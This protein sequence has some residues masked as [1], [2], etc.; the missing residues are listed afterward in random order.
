MTTQ[1]SDDFVRRLEK[2]LESAASALKRAGSVTVVSHI[3][4]DGITS[5]AIATM[6]CERLSIPCKT[7]FAP[8]LNEEYIG[9][10]NAADSDLVWVTDLGSG[11]LSEFTKSPMIV[12]DHHVPDPKW[13]KGQTMLD[14]FTELHHINP[15]CYGLDGATEACGATMTYLLSR[16]VDEG[17][18]D[19]AYLAVVGA[20]G[21][22]QDDQEEG[23][24]GLNTEP[25]WDAKDLGDVEI[26]SDLR[27]F[28]KETRSLVQ[29][30]QYSDPSIPGLTNESSECVKFL[31]SLNIS[32][33]EEGKNRTWNDLSR[34]EKTA[35][36][37]AIIA[38]MTGSDR[39]RVYGPT[40]KLVK[41]PRHTELRDSKEFATLLNSCGRYED[42][43][44]G[45][46]I[47]MEDPDALEKAKKNRQEH[48]KN[49]S[50]AI[51][52]VK[53][54]GLVK[55]RR[56]ILYFFAGSEIKDTVVGIVAG[57][58]LNTEG[59]RRDM[60]IVAFADSDDGVKVSARADRM[61]VRKGLDLSSVMKIAS[62]MV[63]GYGGGHNIAAG[64]TIPKG[65]E[66]VFLD[67]VD[68]MV[69]AQLI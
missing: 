48:R 61:L 41:F 58:I 65:K 33:K 28:G 39:R 35:I 2:D 63:G 15:H 43:E 32:P 36:R 26:D 24:T 27:L 7:I 69:L 40:Y 13:R 11:Y 29:F 45:M 1:N 54:S 50:S 64:A 57:M 20:C 10:I 60:P 47:C 17:N 66:E 46:R 49:I 67:A 12:T 21:D 37:S 30:L 55:M 8:K 31:S 9:Q 23:L 59:F 16:T 25:L 18:V 14:S 19:L 62:E 22:I 5:G 4:A 52:L 6:T 56:S 38:R 3:D 34:E 51:A 68:D 42:A 53:E 44:T